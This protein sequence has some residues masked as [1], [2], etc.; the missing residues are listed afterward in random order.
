MNI[1][2]STV[3]Q[4]NTNFDPLCR[5]FEIMKFSSITYGLHKKAIERWIDNN[6]HTAIKEQVNQTYQIR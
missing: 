2:N 5:T 6:T 3:N 1:E 4:Q